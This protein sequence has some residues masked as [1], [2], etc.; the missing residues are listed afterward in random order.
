MGIPIA[1]RGSLESSKRVSGRLLPPSIAQPLPC[2]GNFECRPIPRVTLLQPHCR[3]TRLT[4]D[5]SHDISSLQ[6][7]RSDYV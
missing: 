4:R 5:I 1:S 2:P 6:C 7:R 3:D